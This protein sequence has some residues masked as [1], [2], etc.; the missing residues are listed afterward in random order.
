MMYAT[1]P[2][3]SAKRT[4]TT[5]DSISVRI[6]GSAAAAA[7][8]SSA[9]ALPDRKAADRKLSGINDLALRQWNEL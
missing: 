4:T 9:F 3:K 2:A 8:I 5:T 1:A 6:Y 7:M